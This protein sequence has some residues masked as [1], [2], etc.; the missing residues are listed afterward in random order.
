[1]SERCP[2]CQSPFV[3]G[4]GKEAYEF[5]KNYFLSWS[6]VAVSVGYASGDIARK[7]AKKYAEERGLL[8]PLPRSTKGACIYVSRKSG[9]TWS[10]IARQYNQSIGEV[11]AQAQKWAKRKNICWPP[12]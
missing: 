3:S 11:Q 5:R 7:A 6:E 4:K 9:Y 8:Y 12:E 10:F 1:M 2:Y